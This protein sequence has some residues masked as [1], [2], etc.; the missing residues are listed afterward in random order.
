VRKSRERERE[1]ET[2]EADNEAV[3]GGVVLVLVL[4]DQGATGLVVRLA[5]YDRGLRQAEARIDT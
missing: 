1:R 5:L 3:L 4:D 2:Y